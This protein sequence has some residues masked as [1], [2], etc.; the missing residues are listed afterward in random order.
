[1]IIKKA[2]KI[3]LL[4]T[5][6][7]ISMAASS[8]T[9]DSSNHAQIQQGVK[10]Y[11]EGQLEDKTNGQNIHVEVNDID[12]RIKVPD[13]PQGFEY[14]ADNQALSQSY[15]SVRVSCNNNQWYL[16]A[17]AQI[18]KTQ[19]VVVT[20]GMLS[21]GTVLSPANL[22]VMQVETN[23]LRHTAYHEVNKLIGARI[24]RRVRQGQPVQSNMLCFVCEGDR[25]TIS[26]E[27][28]GMQVKTSGIAQQDG[29]IGD[30]ITV[31]NASSNKTV[32]AEV[33]STEKVVVRL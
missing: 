21:P 3:L 23:R 18:Q 5:G 17:N 22:T 1:M 8:Q 7:F 6:L 2:S 24:K 11:L 30:T 28:G 33:A 31:V 15:V 10:T 9:K 12:N 20:A 13:C 32:V 16:F 14:F 4:A 19:P 26:A 29:V 27:V 25:I